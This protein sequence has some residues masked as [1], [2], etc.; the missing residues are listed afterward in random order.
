SAASAQS[1]SLGRPLFR[2][3]NSP[4]HWKY[5]S[6]VFTAF[7]AAADVIAAQVDVPVQ[8]VPI[9][10]SEGSAVQL[11]ACCQPIPGDP[12]IGLIRQG[13]GLEVHHCDCPVVTG[14]SGSQ[15]GRWIDVEWEPCPD[16]LY[17]A[18]LRVLTRE[19]LGVLAAVANAISRSESNIQNVTMDKDDFSHILVFTIQVRDRNHLA[20]V[21]RAVRAVPHVIR[22]GRVRP[23]V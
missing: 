3:R 4:L 12:I 11:A 1:W 19:A 13:Y 10:G 9:R 5:I 6:A 14:E 17:V 22:T 8:A 16:R 15:R 2:N 7:F 21:L 18:T 23:G 20:Q